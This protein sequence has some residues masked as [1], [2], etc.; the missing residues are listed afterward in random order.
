MHCKYSIFKIKKHIIILSYILP[1]LDCT[2]PNKHIYIKSLLKQKENEKAL[3][4]IYV[5]Y[6]GSKFAL[7]TRKILLHITNDVFSLYIKTL[8]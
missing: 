2:L 1:D 8:L 6:Q 5:L 3:Y 7:N 4:Y